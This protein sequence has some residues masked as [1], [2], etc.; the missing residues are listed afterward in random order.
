MKLAIYAPDY[1]E[2]TLVPLTINGNP[3]R[4]AGLDT[5]IEFL[6]T[7]LEIVSPE[8][9][10]IQLHPAFPDHLIDA[11]PREFTPTITWDV[12]SMA[13][14]ILGGK[15]A[16]NPGVGTREVGKRLRH[17]V[18]YDGFLHQVYGQSIDAF[19]R[20][21]IWAAQAADAE[22]LASWFRQFFMEHIGTLAGASKL[23]FH[24][25]S[26]D[27]EISK[28]NNKLQVRSLK[29][30]VQFEELT[31]VRA[32]RIQAIEASVEQVHELS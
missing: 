24:S 14:A 29:F 18:V 21:D 16:E 22:R 19:L 11:E 3:I 10:T 5:F 17:E 26:T 31:A 7:A 1:R 28:I 8:D 30:F 23:W 13:P 25:R 2:T 20:F 32:D 4:Q 6:K 9:A 27:R 12:D 15:P